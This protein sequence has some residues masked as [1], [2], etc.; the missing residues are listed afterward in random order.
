MNDTFLQQN[1]LKM[2]D[3][4]VEIPDEV[5][6]NKEDVAEICAL[7]DTICENEDFGRVLKTIYEKSP[8]TIAESKRKL[9]S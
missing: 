8:E 3:D 7:V 5:F 1:P 2:F 6:S 4:F 9:E